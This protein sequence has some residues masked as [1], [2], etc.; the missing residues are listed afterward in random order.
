MQVLFGLLAFVFF[1]FF[2]INKYVLGKRKD[3][4]EYDYSDFPP[5][6]TDWMRC[7]FGTDDRGEDGRVPVILRDNKAEHKQVMR[8]CNGR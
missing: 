8:T 6:I 1:S 7:W 2:V 5:R 3:L 4:N